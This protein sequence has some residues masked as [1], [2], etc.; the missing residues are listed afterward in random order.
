M[1]TG[2]TPLSMKA[3]SS[4]ARYRALSF[5]RRGVEVEVETVDGVD[6]GESGIT[7]T[8]LDGALEAAGLLLVGNS[9]DDVER[10]EILLSGGFDDIGEST[11]HS[12][13][14]KP[15]KLFDGE[16]DQVVVLHELSPGSRV[17]DGGS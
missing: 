11:S 9:A 10:A 16:A 14:T 4:R 2:L 3:R 7:N 5:L 12:G 8:P 15:A 17:M 13:Q 1:K 6:L